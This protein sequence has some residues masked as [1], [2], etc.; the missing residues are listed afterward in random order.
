MSLDQPELLS[1]GQN[2]RFEIRHLCYEV[3]RVLAKGRGLQKPR[4]MPQPVDLSRARE[5]LITVIL[6]RGWLGLPCLS[7]EGSP[8]GVAL[9]DILSA[10]CGRGFP[11][12]LAW[13]AVVDML[14]SRT[15]KPYLVPGKRRGL[16]DVDDAE[17][18]VFIRMTVASFEAYRRSPIV[19]GEIP[20][21]SEQPP[22]EAWETRFRKCRDR[23]SEAEAIHLDIIIEI[24][25]RE[26]RRLTQV[27]LDTIDNR[28]NLSTIKKVC[29]SAVREAVLTSRRGRNGGYGL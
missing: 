13:A 19:A 29:A 17:G 10:V 5:A 18:C 7:D 3:R 6:D 24:L 28:L 1:N 16:L 8:I 25:R 22:Q 4:P 21:A 15:A 27:E 2:I 23:L 12:S 9:Y 11:P 20:A 14:E 26:K